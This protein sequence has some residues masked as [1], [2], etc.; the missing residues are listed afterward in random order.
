MDYLQDNNNLAKL[1]WALMQHNI[2]VEF[3]AHSLDVL[4]SSTSVMQEIRQASGDIGRQIVK[5]WLD[6]NGVV[7]INNVGIKALVK[8][9]Y[10]S[11]ASAMKYILSDL[12]W[13]QVQ[14]KYDGKDYQK[15]IWLREGYTLKAG[16]LHHADGWSRD[17][18]EGEFHFDDRLV[19]D[20][21]PD[22]IAEA[23]CLGRDWSL[24]I[25]MHCLLNWSEFERAT[26]SICE[27]VCRY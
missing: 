21:S 12:G 1:Y 8:E 10:I 20:V 16:F 23:I 24:M 19:S 26:K 22:T 18:E 2:P 9:R 15:S 3:D 27:S 4:G 25:K 17:T 14:A 5:E 7:A 6:G 13:T 11:K